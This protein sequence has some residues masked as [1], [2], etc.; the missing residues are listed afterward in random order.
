MAKKD[1]EKKGPVESFLISI[2]FGPLEVRGFNSLI[3]QKRFED[4]KRQF[5]EQYKQYIQDKRKKSTRQSKGGYSSKKRTGSMDY[6]K[7]GMVLSTVDN[8]KKK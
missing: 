1:E 6:R 2:G 4:A 7:G 8:R 3:R 5:P